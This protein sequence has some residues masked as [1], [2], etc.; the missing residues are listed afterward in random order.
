MYCS[1]FFKLFIAYKTRIRFDV[2]I[3]GQHDYFIH[4]VTFYESKDCKTS[5]TALIHTEVYTTDIS[6]TSFHYYFNNGTIYTTKSPSFCN[7]LPS[8][9]EYLLS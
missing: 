6:S 5:N 3:M 2:F 8:G 1:L 4:D 9:R 7:D